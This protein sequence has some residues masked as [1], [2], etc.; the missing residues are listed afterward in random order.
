MS[1]PRRTVL[2]I[3][4]GLLALGPVACT[5]DASDP[6]PVVEAAAIPAPAPEG[7]VPS[8]DSV[9]IHY[10]VAGQG[11]PALVFIHGWSCDGT[12]WEPQMQ[13]FAA[14]HTVVVLDLAGHGESG[15]QRTD[16]TMAGFGAD[17][18]AV[19][20]A[21]ELERVVLI[22][23]SMGGFVMIE[24]AR[25]LGDRV[26]GL[27][28]AD[29]L[30][31][32]EEVM[33]AAAKEEF[34]A[35]LHAD[36]AARTEAF[37]SQ[38]LLSEQT[39]RALA[40]RIAADMA[41]APPEVGFSALEH[42]LAYNAAAALDEVQL[43]IRCINADKFPTDVESGR[44]HAPS[45]EV[46]IMPGVGHFPMLERPAEFNRLLEAAIGDLV[47]PAELSEPMA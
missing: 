39:D 43:P 3:C 28:G 29:T 6:V 32:V 13:H 16:Y 47:G 36:F 9:P 7:T 5:Q 46:S 35:P 18:R 1:R 25:L 17:V 34:L 38:G 12:Y 14:S 11:L 10:R 19:V 15:A 44:R 24:A 41:A 22:G 20:E 21:L 27:I 4:A 40:D 31:T 8:I 2:S 42:T 30:H 33:D 26:V 37:V 23:H 45:F